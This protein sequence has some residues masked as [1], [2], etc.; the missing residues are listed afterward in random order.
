MIPLDEIV[1]SDLRNYIKDEQGDPWI[2]TP[3]EGYVN[4]ENGQKGTFGEMFVENY[5]KHLGFTIDKRT[6]V[7]HDSIID[8]KKIEIKFSIANKVNGVPRK[9]R[10][11]INHISLSKDWDRLVFFGINPV[12]E[13][14]RF[15]FFDKEDFQTN[16]QNLKDKKIIS[17]QQSGNRGELDDFVVQKSKVPK[18]YNQ[19]WVYDIHDWN[20]SGEVTKNISEGL[21]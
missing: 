15:L 10:Y 8:G 16:I 21:W 4:L 12:Y 2:G 20:K 13:E 7:S 1:T 17:H 19:P 5:M 6:D 3:F 11:L 9:D 18:L 14:S